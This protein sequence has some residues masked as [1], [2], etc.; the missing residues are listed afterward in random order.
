[1]SK[2]PFSSSSVAADGFLCRAQT[3]DLLH[4]HVCH[5]GRAHCDA[6]RGKPR[7]RAEAVQSSPSAA[8]GAGVQPQGSRPRRR[9]ERRTVI[10]GHGS[11]RA[12]L[13]LFVLLFQVFLLLSGQAGPVGAGSAAPEPGRGVP[14]LSALFVVFLWTF[15]PFLAVCVAIF[16]GWMMQKQTHRV[17]QGPPLCSSHN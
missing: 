9:G 10:N 17:L 16:L 12:P 6:V 14:F 2:N 1:M 3:K 5:E 8:V 15:R 4:S 13:I 7:Q 11:V